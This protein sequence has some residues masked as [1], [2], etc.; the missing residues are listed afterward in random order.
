MNESVLYFYL[1]KRLWPES[2]PDIDDFTWPGY[3]DGVYCWTL[4][5]YFRLKKSG[6]KCS[7][8]SEIP[9]EGIIVSHRGCLDDS[10]IPNKNQLLVCMQADWS[11]HPYAQVHIVQNPYQQY[12]KYTPIL[13]RLF[14]PGKRY[15]I[16]LWPQPGLIGRD[17]ARGS[18]IRHIAYLGRP[19]NL[20]NELKTKDWEDF[21]RQL[22]L[23]W[24]LVDE[25]DKWADYSEIDMTLSVRSFSQSSWYFKP[26]TKLYNSWNAG[27]IPV[28]GPESAYI[29][30][31][32]DKY[33]CIIVDSY[34]ELKEK[35]TKLLAEPSEITKYFEGAKKRAD[36][37]SVDS[38]VNDWRKLAANHLNVDLQLWR[39]RSSL[40][41]YI[42][43]YIRWTGYWINVFKNVRL[44][45]TNTSA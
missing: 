37:V 7:L 5:T 43:I 32:K 38:I 39:G 16:R 41:R 2:L 24:S 21:T 15:F 22:D 30:E 4:Q 20:D 12:N 14:V 13:D 11:R 25:P 31:H 19:D 42:Y 17:E 34:G 10:I 3:K 9:D 28:C 27:V 44:G 1:P 6:F 40:Y 33:D 29:A 36:D 8:V 23:K 26:A 45:N 18:K 35:L